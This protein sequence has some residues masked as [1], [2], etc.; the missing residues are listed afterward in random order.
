[1]KKK[2]IGPTTSPR[3]KLK[4]C[5]VV[6]RGRGQIAKKAYVSYDQSGRLSSEGGGI[7]TTQVKSRLG[8]GEGNSMQFKTSLLYFG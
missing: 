3:G 7:P 6:K 1:M 5:G 4:S 8:R 2:K